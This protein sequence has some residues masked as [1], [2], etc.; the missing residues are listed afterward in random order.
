MRQDRPRVREEVPEV[1]EAVA[2]VRLGQTEAW[3]I[4]FR[5]YQMPLYVYICEVVGDD[6]AALDLVQET[7]MRAAKY[8]G[9]LR[10]EARFGAWLFGIAH[11]RCIEWFRKRRLQTTPL[12]EVE[13]SVAAIAV[14]EWDPAAML[15]RQEDA[16]AVLAALDQLPTFHRAVLI[17]HEMDELSLDEIAGVLKVPL[18]TVKSRL[19]NARKALRRMLQQEERG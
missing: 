2:K 19:F 12:E 10:E 4:L 17:L 5:R 11:Q 7:F 14:D 15:V 1:R 8:V 16:Q 6:S 9:Q 13:D 18:G 3:D